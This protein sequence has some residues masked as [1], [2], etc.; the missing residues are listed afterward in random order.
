[1]FWAIVVLIF[2]MFYSM[3]QTSKIKQKQAEMT[4]RGVFMEH[5]WQK[6]SIYF[7]RLWDNFY[8]GDKSCMPKEYISYCMR[9]KEAARD[10]L[11][12][13]AS[14]QE[15]NEGLKPCIIWGDFDKR[16]YDPFRHFHARYDAFIKEYNENGVYCA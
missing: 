1:M 13:L 7:G 9:N 3:G 15:F 12:A 14:E 5:D 10:W 2:Y 8:L 11:C 6:H 16:T 4:E